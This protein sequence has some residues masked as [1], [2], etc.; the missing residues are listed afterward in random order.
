MIGEITQF[1]IHDLWGGKQ[2]NLVFSDNKLIIVGENGSGKTTVLR[3]LFETLACRWAPLS[4]EDF[5]QIELMFVNGETL[6]IN[7]DE[8][9]VARKMFVDNDSTLIRELPFQIRHELA[10]RARISGREISYDQILEITEEYGLTNSR[11]HTKIK[12]K[13]D[14]I[15]SNTLSEYSRTIKEK[16]G[17]QIMY[18]PTYRRVE[19]KIAFDDERNIHHPGYLTPSNFTP[20]KMM[21]DNSVEIA[22]NGMDDVELFIQS[23][24]KNIRRKADISASRLNFLCFK[25]ILNKMS[26]TVKYDKSILSEEEIAKVFGSINEQVL[27]P[28]ESQQ[29]K[30]Q[31]EIIASTQEPISQSYDQIVYYYYYMLHDRLLKL[32]Q[33]EKLIIEF[34]S[35]CNAYL[36]NKQFVYN[37]KEYSY[38]IELLEKSE[39]NTIDLENLSSGEKQVVSIFSYLYLS[40]LSKALVLIDEPELSLSVPWQRTFLQDISKGSKC[41]GVISVTHSPFVFDNDMRQYA[42]SL[43]EFVSP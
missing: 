17:C 29:I 12:E 26:N 14:E 8:L 5:T 18:L 2:V 43:E 15:Q 38:S 27:S 22:K 10:E 35:A 36:T 25:G 42:H 21:Y 24:L 1:Q 3:I 30:Q 9:V 41:A 39:R 13:I 7:K 32:K 16:L 11:L 4:L 33:N 34:F 20:S 28:E 40:P 19:K 23:E 37:E 6:L 31:L